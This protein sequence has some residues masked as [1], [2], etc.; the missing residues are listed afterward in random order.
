MYFVFSE[1]IS[2]KGNPEAELREILFFEN[3]T[4]KFQANNRAELIKKLQ[5]NHNVD[6]ILMDIQIP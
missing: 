1:L 4:L 3:S 5:E 2:P 6:I